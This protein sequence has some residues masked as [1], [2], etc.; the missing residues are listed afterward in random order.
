MKK[1][2][3]ALSTEE[4]RAKWRGQYA[5]RKEYLRVWREANKERLREKRH[6][7]G[8]KNTEYM[9]AYRAANRE[10]LNAYHR[11]WMRAKRASDPVFYAA[12]LKYQSD[13]Y[14]R[15]KLERTINESGRAN[16]NL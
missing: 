9:R 15:K 12:E 1:G 7:R 6:A 16:E 11:D 2:V 5:E 14:A 10:K 8:T 13:R 3:P 4:Q